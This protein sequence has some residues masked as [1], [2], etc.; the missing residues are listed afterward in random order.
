M[1]DKPGEV[2]SEHAKR[3]ALDITAFV[4]ADNRPTALEP[5]GGA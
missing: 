1:E 4:L 3:D 2:P 5:Y